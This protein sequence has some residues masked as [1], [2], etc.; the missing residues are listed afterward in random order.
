MRVRPAYL[1]IWA[2]VCAYAA[3]PQPPCGSE[4]I[5]GYP[6]VA[7]SPLIQVWDRAPAAPDWIPPACTGWTTPGYSTLL[8]TTARFPYPAG[9]Q[10]MLRKI[11]A[12]SET[13][14]MQ[15]WSTTHQRW[16]TL[17]VEAHAVEGP[18]G[19]HRRKDYAPEE[20]TAG[21]TLYF[22]QEDSLTGRATYALRI[23]SFSP[24]RLV[25]ET[26]NLTTLRYFMVPMFHP[27]EVQSVYFLERD[28]DR[29][30]VLRYYNLAR[31]GRNASTLTQGHDA[32]SINR[33]VAFYRHLA[34][35]PTDQDPPAAR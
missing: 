22:S 1:A 21:R 34:G 2:A 31:T 24:D 7:Q 33:A 29:K 16:Q 9:M 12:I 18:T 26:E 35:I 17:I 27:G 25:F 13:A 20:L 4:A 28:P 8:A 10:A 3:G 32:S 30:D 11:G 19:D 14:G 15:Y 6:D 23:L 5:P